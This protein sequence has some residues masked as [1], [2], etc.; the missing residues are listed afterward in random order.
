S[1]VSMYNV[2]WTHSL[3]CFEFVELTLILYGSAWLDKQ[4]DIIRFCGEREIDPEMK[5]EILKDIPHYFVIGIEL[6]AE[7]E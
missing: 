2:H 5:A 7:K 1:R 3:H 6:K 4:H